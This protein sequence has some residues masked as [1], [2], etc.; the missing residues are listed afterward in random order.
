[1]KLFKVS[2]TSCD[3][4]CVEHVLVLARTESEAILLSKKYMNEPKT[5]EELDLNKK[6]V[7]HCDVKWG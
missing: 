6:G 5:V 4:D 3:W 1:M 2:D 7:L